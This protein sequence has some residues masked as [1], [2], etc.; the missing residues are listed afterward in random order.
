[1]R[2]RK[3]K[4]DLKL[5]DETGEIHG[6]V[7]I[8]LDESVA[9]KGERIADDLKFYI[10]AETVSVDAYIK[11]IREKRFRKDLLARAIV[12]L[13]QELADQLEDREGWNGDDR[14]EKV[15]NHFKKML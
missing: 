10:S 7:M 14:Q 2:K 6:R 5:T 9:F 3:L 4:L 11:V 15:E 1:M 13:G 12:S 8:D